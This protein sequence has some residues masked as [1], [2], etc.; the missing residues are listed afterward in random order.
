[1]RACRGIPD[2]EWRRFA[3]HSRRGGRQA[4]R[5]DVGA[6]CIR[7]TSRCGWRRRRFRRKRCSKKC[8]T[9]CSPR[10]PQRKRVLI[11]ESREGFETLAAILGA[12]F[13]LVAVRDTLAEKIG[14]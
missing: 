14:C 12:E 8:S 13:T 5:A 6:A 1:M 2:G 4:R 11:A 9:S 10:R 3:Y 7:T